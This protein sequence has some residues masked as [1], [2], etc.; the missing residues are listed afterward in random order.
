MKPKILKVRFKEVK[1]VKL[2]MI[3]MIDKCSYNY[4]NTDNTSYNKNKMSTKLLR[5]RVRNNFKDSSTKY[6]NNLIKR[7]ANGININK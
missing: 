7:S 5:A 6:W 2:Q 3:K 1:K 4:K